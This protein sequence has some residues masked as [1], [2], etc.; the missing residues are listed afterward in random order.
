MEQTKGCFLFTLCVVRSLRLGRGAI[1]SKL[2]NC[3]LPV[4]A[5][6]FSCFKSSLIKPLKT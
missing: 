3:F 5:V 4:E 1:S 2:E 6:N